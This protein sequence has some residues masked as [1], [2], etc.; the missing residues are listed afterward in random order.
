MFIDTH[1]H[2]LEG[3]ADSF[4]RI[5]EIVDKARNLGLDGI[6]ITDHDSLSAREYAIE[7]GKRND[8]KI[9]VGGE[10]LTYEG[11]IVVFGLDE[12]PNRKLH[13]QELIDLV[14]SK[15]GATISAHPFRDNNRGC[16]NNIRE[17]N[18]LTAVEIF[19]GSTKVHHNLQAFALALELGL[20]T[21]AASDCH[22]V[23]TIGTYC[24]IFPDDV[25]TEEDLIRAIKE[26]KV[27][28]A[29]Y[30]DGKYIKI[31]GYGKYGEEF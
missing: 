30:K 27:Y 17:F 18:G 26:K 25:K 16:G 8:F 4:I 21:V 31:N 19:N 28:P 7:Y 14:N 5:S 6:C 10:I 1:M 12:V 22:E 9:F 13:A 15:G 20:A 29:V 2:C 3:S 24:T 23:K 11:D